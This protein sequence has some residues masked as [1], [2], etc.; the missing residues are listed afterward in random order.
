MPSRNQ[1]QVDPATEHTQDCLLSRRER[2]TV[3]TGLAIP[4]RLQQEQS[5]WLFVSGWFLDLPYRVV[6]IRQVLDAGDSHRARQ[7]VCPAGSLGSGGGF[8]GVRSCDAAVLW[9]IFF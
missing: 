5:C 1:I 7:Y 3:R 9:F 8:A 2:V 4:G 6:T